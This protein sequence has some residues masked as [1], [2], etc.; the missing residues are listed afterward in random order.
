MICRRDG[1]D[2]L[3]IDAAGHASLVA[4]LVNA[5][6]NEFVEPPHRPESLRRAAAILAV[7]HDEPVVAGEVDA[8]ASRPA[9]RRQ[10][11]GRAAAAWKDFHR[12]W[13]TVLQQAASE[14]DAY[15]GLLASITALRA[16]ADFDRRWPAQPEPTDREL[17]RQFEFNKFQQREVEWQDACRR[18]LGLADDGPRQLGLDVSPIDVRERRLSRDHCWLGLIE[19]MSDMLLRGTGPNEPP[20]TLVARTGRP[21]EIRVER[22]SENRLRVKPWPFC[23][24]SIDNAITAKRYVSGRQTLATPVSERVA[25]SV[26]AV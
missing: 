16:S 23:V 19:A 10:P 4:A 26:V 25:L 3:V 2:L 7:R 9:S 5:A 20:P 22:P 14:S 8:G 21:I 15:S 12:V 17:R 13:S 6:G 18:D 11:N 24:P 1:N